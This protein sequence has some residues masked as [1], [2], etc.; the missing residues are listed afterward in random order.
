TG[1]DT[2]G[3][4]LD[5]SQTNRRPV[6]VLAMGAIESARMA[7]ASCGSVPN[8][9]HFGSNLMVHLRKYVQFRL[10]NLPSGITLNDQELTVLL[11]R[12]RA[13]INGTPMHFH[14]QIVAS[15][16]PASNSG[17]NAEALLFQSVPDLDH[18]R[19]FANTPPGV[20]D[21]VIRAVGEMPPNPA[22]N[23]TIG[24][25]LDEY[26]VPRANVN[27]T[28][29]GTQQLMAAIDQTIDF[30]AQAVF[31]KTTNAASVTP[32]GLGTTF[33]ESGTLRI[34]NDPARSAANADCQFHHV[35]NLYT[36]DA[37]VLP[38]CGSANPVMNGV[39][40]RRRLA[41]RIAPEGE[42]DRS[43]ERRV[44]KGCGGRGR[45]YD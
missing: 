6:V 27:L 18:V 5:L 19:T 28:R 20:I 38:T 33:H 40:I 45:Q 11:V 44:G 37:A 17:V 7:L 30:V 39:G 14:L 12:C 35:T 1:I 43:E 42:A 25:E 32:D 21:V 34:G 16:V 4:F 2:S 29:T 23:V 13:Q 22:N 10:N 15:A 3:G 9:N 24:A 31:G 36:G 41:K 26:G 8:T